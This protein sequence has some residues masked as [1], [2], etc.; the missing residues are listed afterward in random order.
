MN[1]WHVVAD[2]MYFVTKGNPSGNFLTT[3]FNCL[4]LAVCIIY[5]F[6]LWNLVIL[7]TY[8]TIA[9]IIK[10]LRMKLFGDDNLITVGEEFDGFGIGALSIGFAKL[11]LEY[12]DWK[13][14]DV[15][16]K[17]KDRWIAENNTSSI[18]E[19]QFLKR[20]FYKR[21][22]SIFAPISVDLIKDMTNWCSSKD[23]IEVATLRSCFAALCEMYHWGKTQFNELRRE[24]NSKIEPILGVYFKITYDDLLAK[25]WKQ[26]ID[27]KIE[28]PFNSPEYLDK[29]F[30]VER[31]T[32][33][34]TI[35]RQQLAA[36]AKSLAK[37]RPLLRGNQCYNGKQKT[38]TD[39]SNKDLITPKGQMKR[40]QEEKS[41]EGVV[42]NTL[43]SL[44]KISSALTS[45]PIIG[46]VAS[47]ANPIFSIAHDIAKGLGY[48]DPRSIA[49]T[50]RYI[51][52]ST[53]SFAQG[54]GLDNAESVAFDPQNQVSNDQSFFIEKHGP[55]DQLS[56]YFTRPG[57]LNCFSFDGADAAGTV[58][59]KKPINP[60][61][62]IQVSTDVYAIH[63]LANVASNFRY[64]RGSIKYLIQF[65]TSKFVTTRVRIEQLPDPTLDADVTDSSA[66]D[67]LSLTVDVCGDTIVPFTI[68]YLK[69]TP[70]LVVPS[71]DKLA[72]TNVATWQ[73]VCNGAFVIR[74]VHPP[75]SIGA[76]ADAT[77]DVA[78]WIAGGEDMQFARLTNIWDEFV[79]N[80]TPVAPPMAE[81]VDEDYNNN[82]L[83]PQR[84]LTTTPPKGEPVEVKK[85]SAAKLRGQMA[86]MQDQFKTVF[87]PLAPAKFSITKNIL[88]GEQILSWTEM[89]HRTTYV[90]TLGWF[91]STQSFASINPWR[92]SDFSNKYL[93]R[94][95][96]FINSFNFHRGNVR[97]RFMQRDTY[98]NSVVNL[99]NY[100]NDPLNTVE[101]ETVIDFSEKGYTYNY[102]D[103]RQA[104]E[105]EIPFYGIYPLICPQFD[106]EK[107]EWPGCQF[108]ISEIDLVARAHSFDVMLSTADNYS[109]AWPMP[110][111][112]F[113][114]QSLSRKVK[115]QMMTNDTAHGNEDRKVIETQVQENTQLSSFR[116]TVGLVSDD[117]NSI[118]PLHRDAD[119]Y[120]DQGLTQ[121]LSR[122]YIVQQIT[123]TNLQA[124]GTK[125]GQGDSPRELLNIDKI[126]ETLNRFKYFR[127]CTEIEFRLNSTTYHSGKLVVFYAPHWNPTGA[128]TV[129][130][131]DDMY[132]LSCL[133]SVCISACANETVRFSIPYIAPSSYFDLQNDPTN[134]SFK[135]FFGTYKI[136]VLA[137]LRL[138][139]AATASL[140]LTVYANFVQPEVAGFIPKDTLTE[141][142]LRRAENAKFKDSSKK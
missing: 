72:T 26:K 112:Y 103:K 9:Q 91:A 69:D 118:T 77:V 85:I 110:P 117:H 108:S 93:G 84:K 13:K 133:D 83:K 50:E 96:R 52:Q 33:L 140:T 31:D 10:I 128:S 126:F 109:C 74:V 29:F 116:D 125:I 100:V 121:V 87:K 81:V 59:I 136:F 73:D 113:I 95:G 76:P 41:K 142:Q 80:T 88:Q 14:G 99:A 79:Y 67:V 135:G 49:T 30:D 122:K 134:A 39:F 40:E 38:T 45:V 11:G 42:S 60:M 12:T 131:S 139:G 4:T 97:Y 115:G 119:P 19:I 90:E 71:P 82:N 28:L 43:N 127:A 5:S 92:W 32:I 44:K 36:E 8:L 62:M 7:K 47:F 129:G 46:E 57:L 78:I 86:T 22:Y 105:V 101:S 68:P 6:W 132:S 15:V 94:W 104:N 107:Y 1:R 66:G 56:N 20:Y 64:W 63:C 27:H 102:Q 138:V 65:T 24:I 48:D 34:D 54:R 61:D 98:Y 35:H 89:Q 37:H 70:W 3:V 16:W 124:V 111:G 123:W 17:D 130:S 114:K 58:L 55:T 141:R 75:N 23:S 25:Y 137:P 120:G 106:I 18:Y 51:V 53:S 21:N 2:K